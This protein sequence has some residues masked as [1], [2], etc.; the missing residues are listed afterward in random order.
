L[1]GRRN[2]S[3]CSPIRATRKSRARIASVARTETGGESPR[4]A[5]TIFLNAQIITLDNRRPRARALAIEHGHIAKIGTDQKVLSV[6]GKDTEV[7]NL[8]A[9]TVLPGFTDC[10]THL[11]GYAIQL[12]GASL[13]K[14]TSISEIESILR[15]QAEKTDVG[16]WVLGYGWDQEKLEERRFPNRFDLDAAVSDRPVCIFRVCEHVCVANSAALRRANVTR[17]TASPIGGVIDRQDGMGE[18]TGVL[19]ENAMDLVLCH[20][21]PLDGAELRKAITLA[22]RKAVSAGLTSIHCVVD[23]PQHVRVLQAMNRAGELRARIYV[24]IP[25]GWLDP[26]GRVG[27]STGFGD[28]MLRIQAIKVFTDG[29]LGARTAALDTPYSDSPDTRGILMHSQDQLNSIVEYASRQGFQVAIH[30]IGDHAISMAL[31]AIENARITVPQS[32]RLRHR[33]E[34]ASV[35]NPDLIKRVKLARVIASVQPHFIPSDSWVPARV[36]RERAKFVYALKSLLKSGATVVGGSDCPVEPI[37]PLEGISAAVTSATEDYGERVGIQEAL[38]MFTKKAAYATHEEK[39]KGTIQEGKMADLVVLDRNPLMVSPEEI[40]KIK[41]LA[42]VV[43]GRIM[44]ASRRFQ[45]MKASNGRHRPARRRSRTRSP[46]GKL[47]A[48]P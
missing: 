1:S 39:L 45:A 37:D 21:P 11:V 28:D 23:Q 18:P 10:H 29:S 7:W 32:D 13:R 15:K 25:D 20:I 40:R 36:G 43:G 22:M 3:A 5:D 12:Y 4:D 6:A 44:Y 42:T 48:L 41:V 9:A 34:H 33:I 24:L 30:A 17:T 31:T 46:S 8:D 47:R 38:E 19:R 26:A 2:T 16:A 35:L 27:I 14:A